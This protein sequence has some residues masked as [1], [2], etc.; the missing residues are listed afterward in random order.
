[1]SNIVES[2]VNSGKQQ[3]ETLRRFVT[4]ARGPFETAD[5]MVTRFRRANQSTIEQITGRGIGGKFLKG[6]F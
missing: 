5:E 2:R 1:M 6:G 4:Q 3:I